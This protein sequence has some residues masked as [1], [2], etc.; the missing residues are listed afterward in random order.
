MTCIVA[1]ALS[2]IQL[3][4][5]DRDVRRI[6][7]HDVVLLPQYTL[8]LLRL[9]Q[10]VDRRRPALVS[11]EPRLVRHALARARPAVAVQQAIASRDINGPAWRV[12]EPL[13]AAG[14]Q[15]G[16]D[17]AEAGNGHG[18]GVEVHPENGIESALG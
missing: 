18:K 5:L 16:N 13:D 1:L 11:R 8:Q 6:P 7:H 2:R 12:F 14:V 9:L 3:S 15:R 10:S 17:E 4:I